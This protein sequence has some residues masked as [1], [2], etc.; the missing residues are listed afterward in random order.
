MAIVEMKKMHLLGL[1]KEQDK[2]LSIL[3]KAGKVEIIEVIDEPD[4]GTD[5]DQIGLDKELSKFDQKLTRLKFGIDFLK[6]YVQEKNPLLYGKPR[7]NE[8]EV[9]ELLSDGKLIDTK[10]D[11]LYE[12]DQRFS[13]LKAEESKLNS[14]IELMSIWQQMDIPVEQLGNTQKAVFLPLVV[15]KKELEGFKTSLSDMKIESHIFNVSESR[16]D[17]YMLLVF[18]QE[19]KDEVQE[20]IKQY[21]ANVQDFPGLAGTPQEIV[22]NDRRRLLDIEK[23]R[24]QIRQA[25]AELA[26]Y[27]FKFEILYDYWS[28]ERDKKA[29]IQKVVQTDKA[30]YLTAWVPK[31]NAEQVKQKITNSI[32][33][34][35]INFTDPGEDEQIP[36]VLSNPRIVQPFEMITELYS[37]PDPKGI[38]PNIFMAPFYFVFFGMMV[39]D[40]GYGLVLSILMGIAMWKLKLAGMGKKLVELLFL[41]GISTFIWG[42]IFGGWFGDL[43]K[44][45]PLWLNP[46]DDPMTVLV[47]SFIFG[48]IQIYSGL[49]L[50]AY[51]NIRDG[52][53]ADAFMDQ[54]MWIIFL[55]GLIM[56]AFPQL[57]PIAKYVAIVGAVGLLLT[58]GRSQKGIIKKFTSGLLSLYDVTGYLS[59]VLSYSRLLALGLAT[60]VIGTV[61]NTMAKLVGVNIIGVILMV[62][63]MIGGHIF[64]IAINVLGA[65]VHS[66][67]LQ[68]I[69]F[70]GKFYDSG[71]RAFDPLKIRTTFVEFEDI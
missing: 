21:S 71:G 54:G 52:H 14:R 48:I 4:R 6:P 62:I 31:P 39:S 41:G 34:V 50:S 37:L 3:Q 19:Q 7:V 61:I 67:R 33:A 16:D 38:D 42:A 60:G 64:N 57:R 45:K 25:S 2:I 59:D 32:E 68:Y 28:L 20:L 43:I 27:R 66:S 12:L 9:K 8:Q 53:S 69:E 17:A 29:G 10:L 15:S 23:E 24:E 47:V 63:I 26:D 56:L 30:F 36:V 5:N 13:H 44:L 65:Y 46:L 58:Q 35:C 11:D 22:E 40:A 49:L 70:F 1:R 55:S 51:K 18:L